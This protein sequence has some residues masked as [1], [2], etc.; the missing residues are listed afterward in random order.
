MHAINFQNNGYTQPQF[1]KVIYVGGGSKNLDFYSFL[2]SSSYFTEWFRTNIL[3]G[4]H[5]PDCETTFKWRFTSGP[6]MAPFDGVI[7]QGG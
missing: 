3:S 7:F 4:H 5:R 2:L 6:M 1:H